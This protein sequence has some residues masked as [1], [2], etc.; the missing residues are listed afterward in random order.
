MFA[1]A[2]SKA[3]KNSGNFSR[4]TSKLPPRTIQCAFGYELEFSQWLVCE[5]PSE[6]LFAQTPVPVDACAL[7][8]KGDVLV[9]H[10]LLEL[11]AENFPNGKS[12]LEI[13]S[14]PFDDSLKG[15]EELQKSLLI[16]RQVCE[17][18]QKNRE[19][20]KLDKFE[21]SDLGKVMRDRAFLY[22][23]ASN[24]WPITPQVT[25]GLKLSQFD[26]MF[27]DFGLGAEIESDRL[28]DRRLFGRKV[29]G[30]NKYNGFNTRTYM[31]GKTAR[32]LDRGLKEFW[33][34]YPVP[35]PPASPELIGLLSLMHNYIYF[36]S[37]SL[38]IYP[39]GFTFFLMRTDFSQLFK[40]LPS[41]EQD[42]FSESKGQNWLSLFEWLLS[43][44]NIYLYPPLEYMYDDPGYD[45][46][47]F[48]GPEKG[49][50]VPLFSSGVYTDREKY[51]QYPVDLMKNLS[52]KDWILAISQG[53]DLLTSSMYP[54]ECVKPHLEALGGFGEKTDQLESGDPAPVFELRSLRTG[55]NLTELFPLL[56]SFFAY[57]YSKNRGMDYKLGEPVDKMLPL[58]D[59]FQESGAQDQ[60]DS[61]SEEKLS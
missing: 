56:L 14:K 32:V 61:R 57:F 18:L 15:F 30:S 53:T 58:A 1:K 54:D 22:Y 31:M 45:I 34:M 24:Y 35:L 59:A 36:A 47:L 44:R 20:I 25:A 27:R 6:E 33:E 41:H 21:R 26:S 38:P 37:L 52:R 39:K 48:C 5:A 43:E 51:P 60:M 50:N 46:L 12:G 7:L 28:A 40:L 13:V 4:G 42:Y 11:Q 19:Q 29:V 16:V 8:N 10:D 17:L 55:H 9:K 3:K 49:L 2:S 23:A